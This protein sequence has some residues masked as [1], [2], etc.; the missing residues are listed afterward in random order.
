ML[1][2]CVWYSL[3]LHQSLAGVVSSR[4][5]ATWNLNP[6]GSVFH[7]PSCC[8]LWS[9][10]HIEWIFYSHVISWQYAM[11][12]RKMLAYWVKKLFQILTH[13]FMQYF[14]ILF[15][16]ISTSLIIKV[17]SIEKQSSSQLVKPTLLIF[18][19]LLVF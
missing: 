3:I 16:N 15:I 12:I 19:A 4:L 17:W 7:T 1:D 10:S 8:N 11:V 2:D 6:P 13:I 9:V 14:K 5:I 18:R